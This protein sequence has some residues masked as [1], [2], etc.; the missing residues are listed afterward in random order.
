MLDIRMIAVKRIQVVE[1]NCSAFKFNPSRLS[2]YSII[3][4][5]YEV[6]QLDFCHYHCCWIWTQRPYPYR[7]KP[8]CLSFD[9][10]RIFDSKM[11][12]GPRVLLPY[13]S[14]I[15]CQI[16]QTT[17]KAL[18][19]SEEKVSGACPTQVSKPSSDGPQAS[20]IDWIVLATDRNK[21]HTSVG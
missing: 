3:T 13:T 8:N 9:P 14:L 6:C 15:L 5:V 18:S 20:V 21:Q 1:S 17:I 12:V 10:F 2:S 19:S 11:A 16:N 4:I 7:V